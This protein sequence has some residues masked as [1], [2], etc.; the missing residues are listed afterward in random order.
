M[1]EREALVAEGIPWA[2]KSGRSCH[3]LMCIYYEEHLE[4]PLVDVQEE[5]KIVPCKVDLDA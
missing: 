3:D 1:N 4:R 5:F 2:I